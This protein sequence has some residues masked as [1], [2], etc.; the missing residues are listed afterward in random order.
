MD[1]WNKKKYGTPVV[2]IIIIIIIIIII[3]NILVCVCVCVWE[4]D[5][6]MWGFYSEISKI[7]YKT[8]MVGR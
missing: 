8:R 7:I 6:V 2:L 3:T 5:F 1:S 4:R